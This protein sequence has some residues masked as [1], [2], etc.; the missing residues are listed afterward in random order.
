MRELSGKVAV[1]TGAASGIGLGLSRRFAAEGM[2]VV[3]ADI[4]EGALKEAEDGLAA[5]GVD[6]L[7][8][9]T[10][11]TSAESVEELAVRSV[12]RFGAVHVVCNNAGVGG[13]GQMATLTHAQWEWVLGVNL[14][15]VIHGI[16]AFLP[17]FL[18]QGEGHIVNTGSVAG[19]LAAPG[20]G[21]Y[22]ASKFAVVGISE[23]LH[24]ELGML[25]SPVKV[26]VLCPG[27]V[28]TN[29]AESDRNWP[30]RL[31]PPPE[32]GVDPA[33][34]LAREFVRQSLAT[35]MP[36][37]QVAGL[38]LDAIREERFWVLT[39]H[40]MASRVIDRAHGIVDGINPGALGPL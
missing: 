9:P 19:L 16:S 15:G 13:G 24:M 4:E 26:S 33:G 23:S 3:M 11:V 39:E 40:A 1:V 29:I 20:M 37:D 32:R 34:E 5:S 8:V 31:G 25:A 6:T 12:E 28:K 21:P 2:K 30:S 22:C 38:V 36:P 35:G 14:W 17:R 7:R 10:D 27:W 18:A